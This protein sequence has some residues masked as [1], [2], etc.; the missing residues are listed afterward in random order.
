MS[1]PS[2]E[3]VPVGPAG[4]SA[5]PAEDPTVLEGQDALKTIEKVPAASALP[6]I[7]IWQASR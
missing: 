5:A 6:W 7:V 2:R 1:P 3:A 4:A